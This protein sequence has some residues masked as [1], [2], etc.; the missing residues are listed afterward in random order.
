MMA[1]DS[2]EPRNSAMAI[3]TTITPPRLETM[4]KT[5]RGSAERARA[6]MSCSPSGPMATLTNRPKTSSASSQK[7]A[8]AITVP[9]FRRMVRRPSRAASVGRTDI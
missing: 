9:G 7:A 1:A 3:S 4:F 6:A 2:T 5:S 8:Q